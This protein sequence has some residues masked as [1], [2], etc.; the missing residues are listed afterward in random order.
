MVARVVAVTKGDAKVRVDEDLARTQDSH[1]AIEEAKRKAEAETARL[2]V[3]HTSL[4]LDIGAAKDEVSALQS[5]AE[6]DK[7]A[8][9][10]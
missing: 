7:E 6:K 5:Q 3:D 1:A 8:L 2:K 4:L 10:G 9:V